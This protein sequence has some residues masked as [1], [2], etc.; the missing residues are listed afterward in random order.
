MEKANAL[1]RQRELEYN[2]S[3]KL[4]AKGVRS[5]TQVA[6][7]KAAFE[8]AKADALNRTL[9]LENLKIK[10]PFDGIVDARPVEVGD[11]MAINNICATVVDIDPMLVVGQVSENVVNSLI[12]R[13]SRAG[14]SHYRGRTDGAYPLCLVKR[15]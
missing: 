5:E 9:E 3:K 12:H 10:A 7:D 11:L 6:A 4:K 8:S 2:G 13:V 1:V 15:R 14:E